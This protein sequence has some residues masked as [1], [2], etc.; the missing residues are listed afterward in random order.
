MIFPTEK[1]V[2]S[3]GLERSPPMSR[4]AVLC[5]HGMSRVS[6]TASRR[7]QNHAALLAPHLPGLPIAHGRHR[8]KRRAPVTPPQE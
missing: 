8:P 7:R 2:H 3:R 1:L 6:S 5:A 4:D